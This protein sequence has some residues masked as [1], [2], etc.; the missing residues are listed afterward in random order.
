MSPLIRHVNCWIDPFQIAVYSIYT[1]MHQ[2]PIGAFDCF[3]KQISCV[4]PIQAAFFIAITIIWIL[5][6]DFCRRRHV[7]GMDMFFF[8]I[9]ASDGLISVGVGSLRRIQL[10][11]R[12]ISKRLWLHFHSEAAGKISPCSGSCCSPVGPVNSV[13]I[14]RRT[15]T[16]TLDGQTQLVA[17]R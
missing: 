15:A 13:A 17:P 12:S 4:V 8:N 9:D 2:I 14:E 11:K 10:D 1:L 16:I 7:P 6:A 5:S 3:D